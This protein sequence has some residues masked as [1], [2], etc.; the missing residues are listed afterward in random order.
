MDKLKTA[1]QGIFKKT[2]G[3]KDGGPSPDQIPLQPLGKTG[4]SGG[5]LKEKLM[6]QMK[7][8]DPAVIVAVTVVGVL[9][10]TILFLLFL[11]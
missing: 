3:P 1:M 11:R 7:H 8:E 5:Q 10:L 2:A 4:Q 6:E 9:L